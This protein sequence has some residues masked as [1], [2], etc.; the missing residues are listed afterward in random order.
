MHLPKQ[1]PL[2]TLLAVLAVGVAACGG[3]SDASTTS[4]A[5]TPTS[6]TAAA[7]PVTTA[8][9][10]TSEGSET[11]AAAAGPSSQPLKVGL[12]AVNLNS[13]SIAAIKDEFVKNSEGR[14]WTVDVFDGKGDQNA[15]NQAAMDFVSRGYTAIVNDAS[16][17]NQMGAV[18][19]AANAANIP[20]V[21][22]FGGANVDGVAAE[23]AT[24]EFMNGALT[25]T[26]LVNRLGGKGRILKLNWT[27]LQALRDRDAAFHA[28]I[29]ESPGIKI[30]KEIEVKV[31]GQVEDTLNQ[32]T[33]YLQGDKDIQG[34]WLGFD[35]LAP[36]A[37]RAL[38]QAGIADKVVVVT[39]DGNSF[40]WDLIR[41][42]GPLKF[43]PANPFPR[44]GP[45]VADV[46]AQIVDGNPPVPN[47]VDLQPCAITID[48]VPAKGELP[49]YDN[50]EYIPG[51]IT[52][53]G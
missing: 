39:H 4:P 1:A 45:K 25:A 17:N 12:V 15:T 6:S 5:A 29:S 31:P 13:P 40:A 37:V 22:V 3:G 53:R 35:E 36:P 33:N 18:I 23:V 46:L 21:S 42:G 7:S 20:F 2:A 8:A 10:A 16:P 27:V 52:P 48:S 9:P 28:V 26:E 24:N 47:T 19:K 11:T 49:D 44:I 34:V 32:I 14:G 41:K 51:E 43:E 38:E 50:C 30:A